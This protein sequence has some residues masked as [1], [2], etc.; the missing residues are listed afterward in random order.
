VR[1]PVR[2]LRGR[3]PSVLE[4]LANRFVWDDPAVVLDPAVPSERFS[5]AMAAFTVGSTIKITG[6]DRHPHVDQLL[7]DHVGRSGPG[8]MIDSIVLSARLE[9]A[10]AV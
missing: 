8:A 5:A 7:L 3:W 1:A 9:P 10:S 2:P 6:S 4:R